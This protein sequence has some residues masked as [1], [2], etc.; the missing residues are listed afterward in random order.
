MVGMKAIIVTRYGPPE[1]LQCLELPR[2]EPGRR[3]LLISVHAATVTPSDCLLRS[4]KFPWLFW[5]PARLFYGVLRPRHM[6]LGYE[7][8]G[9]VK[10]VGPDVTRFAVGD[11]VY[12]ATMWRASCNAEYLCVPETAPLIHKPKGLP[13]AEAVACVDG[14]CTALHFLTSAGV[15]T[16]MSVAV[17]GASGSVGSAA[18]QLATQMGA[19]V[20]ALCSHANEE[21]VRSLGAHETIDY[22][23][24]DVSE[25]GPR[26]DVVFDAV[27]KLSWRSAIKALKPG[28]VFASTMEMGPISWLRRKWLGVSTDKRAI[29]GMTVTSPERLE[30]V[31]ELF[32]NGVFR[33]VVDRTYPL[34]KAVEAH[35]YV[36]TGRKRGNVVLVVVGERLTAHDD[37]SRITRRSV[38]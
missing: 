4:G 7:M 3:Q 11:A 12:G 5:I 10:S 6:I 36:E 20:T 26:F 14:A 38:D 18:V 32:N 25:G 13:H 33:P 35:R 24:K 9:V 15:G 17:N 30:Y 21:M 23:R 37:V 34:E 19:E 8:S 16:G 28:G 22:K 27:G 2:P 29:G 1:V 31:A